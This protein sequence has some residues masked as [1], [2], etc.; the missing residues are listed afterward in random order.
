MKK[1]FPTIKFQIYSTFSQFKKPQPLLLPTLNF[2]KDFRGDVSK[3]LANVPMFRHC[4]P[5]DLQQI[6]SNMEKRDFADNAVVF[7]QGTKGDAFYVVTAGSAYVMV[8]ASHF[9]KVGQDVILTRD[10]K[11]AGRVYPRE[12]ECVVDK[13]DA[14][15]GYPFTV[16]VLA[17]GDR[18]RVLP[19]EIELAAVHAQ[20]VKIASLLPGDYFGDQALLKGS[21]RNATIVAGQGLS[22]CMLTVQ[23]FQQLNISQK[24]HFAK[25]KAVLAI[26]DEEAARTT[27]SDRD[28]SK[29]PQQAE[30]IKKAILSNKN[31]HEIH[32]L[33]PEDIDAMVRIAYKRP[34]AKATVIFLIIRM[35]VSN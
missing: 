16:R 21:Y 33:T 26:H 13:Y 10:V 18:G 12:T 7:N 30:L 6:S 31:L 22:T 19:E 9:I 32:S 20:D 28:I 5:A 1:S 14:N 11:I 35:V 25:R 3:F 15:R 34:I 4:P 24:L 23:K 27:S 2:M 8:S 29:T 17:T